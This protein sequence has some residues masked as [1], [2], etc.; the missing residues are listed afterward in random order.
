MKHNPNCINHSRTFELLHYNENPLH[1]LEHPFQIDDPRVVK[2]L[3]DGHLV[4]KGGL[5]LGGKP[6]LVNNLELR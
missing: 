2:V 1:R 4:L 3:Q 5:L 6:H